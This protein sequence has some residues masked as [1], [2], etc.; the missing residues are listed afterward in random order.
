MGFRAGVSKLGLS[1][2]LFERGRELTFM[3]AVLIPDFNTENSQ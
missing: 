3:S 2:V 1:F